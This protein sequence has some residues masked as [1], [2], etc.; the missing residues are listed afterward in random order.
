M[1]YFPFYINIGNKNCIIIGGGTV[2]LRKL[3]KLREFN[4]IITVIAP[5]V[6]DEINRFPDIKIIKRKFEDRDIDNAFMVIS[7]TDDKELNTHI[8]ELCSE[9][10]ILI[11][12]VDDKEKCGF[13]FPAL[14]K[15]DNITVGISTSGKSPLYSRF[16][17]E[18]IEK[19]LDEDC[20][21]TVEVLSKYRAEIKKRVS[22]EENRKKAFEMILELCIR[23]T[24]NIDDELIFEI[25][26]GL[27]K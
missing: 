19:L 4:P 24:E 27:N 8:F 16:L 23:G 11:N 26:E 7:A 3:E 9:K 13:I 18:R 1:G 5:S 2:A 12:T 10:N 22:S 17:R 20:D 21:R 25:T 6:C 14:V 15:R